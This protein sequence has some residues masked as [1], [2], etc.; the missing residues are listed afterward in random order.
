MHFSIF[1]DRGN[2]QKGPRSHQSRPCETQ[3]RK[4]EARGHEVVEA[5]QAHPLGEEEQG[6][7]EEGV[8]HQKVGGRG[9]GLIFLFYIVTI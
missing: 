1:S 5:P 9:A 4:E 3:G 8:L 7:P 2:L 6:C